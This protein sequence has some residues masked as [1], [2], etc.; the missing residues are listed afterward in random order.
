MKE[1]EMGRTGELRNA[2]K[3]T[4]PVPEGKRSLGRPRRRWMDDIKMNIGAYSVR[5]CI[6]FMWLRIGSVAGSC[7]LN[8]ESSG[9]IK[10]RES[11]D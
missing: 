9:Y 3:I 4:V 6:G 2:Y 7:E 5:V 1:N 10:C 11:I 8:N